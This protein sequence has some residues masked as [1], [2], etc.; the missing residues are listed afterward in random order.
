MVNIC[1]KHIKSTKTGIQTNHRD[2][3]SFQYLWENTRQGSAL[4]LRCE[5]MQEGRKEMA[6]GLPY[7]LEERQGSIISLKRGRALSLIMKTNVA[8]TKGAMT[9]I[10]AP[11]ACS[12]RFRTV[13]WFKTMIPLNLGVSRLSSGNS[14]SNMIWTYRKSLTTAC[15]D[16]VHT[17]VPF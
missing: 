2:T 13:C 16:V 6:E 17:A 14:F 10:S 5:A 1:E 4:E 3:P 12:K 8:L 9:C 7:F 15:I 11:V